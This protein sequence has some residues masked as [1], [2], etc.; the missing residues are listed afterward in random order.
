MPQAGLNIPIVTALDEAGNLIESDQKR[1]I[2][3][4]IQQG[5]GADSL[6]ICGTTGE[7][8]RLKHS[9]CRRLL[10]IGIE[11]IRRSNKLM[12]EGAPPVEAWAG[13]TAPTKAETLALLEIAAQLKA[14]MAVI[15]P[16]AIADLQP[17]EIVDFF[18]RD[19]AERLRADESLVIG[20]YDNPD[21][22][23]PLNAGRNLPVELINSLKKLPFVACLK[24]SATR[25]AFRDYARA[26]TGSEADDFTLYAGNAGLIFEIDKI[27]LEA[28]IKNSEVVLAGVV[29]GTANLFPREWKQAWRAVVNH[30]AKNISIYKQFFADF[31]SL[32]G[33]PGKNGHSS[34]LIGGIKQAMFHAGIIASPC[35]APGTPALTAD[36]ARRLNEG[37]DELLSEMRAELSAEHLSLG[38]ESDVGFEQRISGGN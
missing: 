33:F 29:S 27:Q 1:I 20:L 2:H 8:N 6:F 24:A 11:E 23:A 10:E 13:V 30:D 21:I 34:K 38:K 35:V 15:A 9:Q 26:F 18:E 31:E 17:S 25:D 14:E 16:Y 36:E 28:E 5:Y 3:Y 37:L 32:T 19:I 12:P 4:T 22:A 7:Y